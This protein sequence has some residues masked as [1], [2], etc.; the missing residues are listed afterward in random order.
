MAEDIRTRLHKVWECVERGSYSITQ[1]YRDPDSDPKSLRDIISRQKLL[2]AVW[3]MMRVPHYYFEP[4]LCEIMQ[5]EGTT[6]SL[7]AMF[8]AKVTRLPFPEMVIEYDEPE[9]TRGGGVVRNF[10]VLGERPQSL[11]VGNEEVFHPYR[12]TILRHVMAPDHHDMVLVSPAEVLIAF[13]AE[14]GD[15]KTFGFHYGMLE[16]PYLDRSKISDERM[17][18]L[19]SRD[20]DLDSAIAG[21]ALSMAT[22]L[23]NTRGI[24]K[25]VI[26]PSRL[27]KAR[28]KKGQAKIPTH[29]VIRIGHVYAK[30]GSSQVYDPTGRKHTR[31]HW[32]KGHTRTQRYGQGLTQAKLVFIE[33]CL[34]NYREGGDEKPVPRAVVRW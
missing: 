18:R 10:I 28:E 25:T 22:L 27:N 21:E 19:L 24:Q 2:N 14:A 17:Q 7:K 4:N 32:R 26:E 1:R 31:V 16:C 34:V 5:E 33:P 9:K 29:T 6:D 3:A 11:V 30:D 12:C 13:D 8:E 15:E 20:V 23:L